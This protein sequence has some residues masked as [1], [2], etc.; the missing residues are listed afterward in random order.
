MPTDWNRQAEYMATVI[1]FHRPFQWTVQIGAARRTVATLTSAQW[2]KMPELA[3][4]DRVLVKFRAGRKL[5]RIVGFAED[6][7]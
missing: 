2:C 5:P 6:R 1:D 3:P 4:G 7:S